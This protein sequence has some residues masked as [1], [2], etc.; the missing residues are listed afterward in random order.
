[1]YYA[2]LLSAW[3]PRWSSFHLA[4]A[5]AD[6]CLAGRVDTILQAI[7]VVAMKRSQLLLRHVD[8][9]ELNGAPEL[10][11]NNAIRRLETLPLR[12]VPKGSR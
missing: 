6:S 1:M 5:L 8:D 2:S 12:L 11:L 3:S 10:A 9:I 4:R 7:E